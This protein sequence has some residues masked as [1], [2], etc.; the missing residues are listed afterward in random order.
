MVSA[1]IP[2][3]LRRASDRFRVRVKASLRGPRHGKRRQLD[4][5]KGRLRRLSFENGLARLSLGPM[6]P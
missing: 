3:D 1:S 6:K 5:D 4:P 2:G